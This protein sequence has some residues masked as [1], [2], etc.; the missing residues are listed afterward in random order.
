MVYKPVPMTREGRERFVAELEYLRL[1]RRPEV[2]ARIHQARDETRPQ[3]SAE[4]EDARHEQTLVERR[5][6]ELEQLL[7]CAVPIDEAACDAAEV[8]VG[9]TVKVLQ[10]TGNE[11]EFTIVGSAEASPLKGRISNESPVG[12]ALLGK[13]I[14]DTVQVAAPAGALT[15]V[16]KAI[17]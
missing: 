15:M 13:R 4:Y 12:R 14:G 10:Q 2:A 3:N 8:R 16:V 7:A 1:V 11:A 9:S 17:R 5:I 6:L